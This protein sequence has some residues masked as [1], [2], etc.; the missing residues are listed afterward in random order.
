MSWNTRR[1][2]QDAGFKF[3]NILEDENG[4]IGG[5]MNYKPVTNPLDKDSDDVKV[6]LT[7]FTC[8]FR[9]KCKSKSIFLYQ[10]KQ[11]SFC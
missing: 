6:Q 4:N 10:K 7:R 2:F 11:V 8:T 9:S 5:C 1:F 3:D